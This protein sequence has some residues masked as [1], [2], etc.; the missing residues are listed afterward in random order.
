MLDGEYRGFKEAKEP[1]KR[2]QEER[3]RYKE[4]M[5]LIDSA[6]YRNVHF[7]LQPPPAS[8]ILLPEFSFRLQKLFDGSLDEYLRESE[9]KFQEYSTK[10]RED[11][12]RPPIDEDG[13]GFQEPLPRRHA[14]I[15]CFE[16]TK[17]DHIAFTAADDPYYKLYKEQTA[18][19]PILC[20]YDSDGNLIKCER[21]ESQKI[22]V[23]LSKLP[24]QVQMLVFVVQVTNPQSK[25][26]KEGDYDRAQ[27]RVLCEDTNQT[28][29]LRK[30]KGMEVP[31]LPEDMPEEERKRAEHYFLAGRVSRIGEE[32]RWTYEGYHLAFRREGRYKDF[33]KLFGELDYDARKDMLNRE[34]TIREIEEEIKIT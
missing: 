33:E 10:M 4:R 23:R 20:T 22:T 30:M 21:S 27:Y 28:I 19:F 34:L 26:F 15:T 31:P 12:A 29:E 11:Q 5:L 24:P 2:A 32:N 18:H 1:A 7:M 8:T 6:H 14:D 13:T 25:F 9:E 17:V 16:V 3:L